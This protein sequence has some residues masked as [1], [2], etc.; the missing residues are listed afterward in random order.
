V[1]GDRLAN[2]VGEGLE[3]AYDEADDIL[4]VRETRPDSGL[5]D[6]AADDWPKII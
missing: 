6:A 2:L 1:F 5:A 3:E 4:V